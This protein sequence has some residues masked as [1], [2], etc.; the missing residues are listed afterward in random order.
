MP[1]RPGS[2]AR[3]AVVAAAVI[4]ALAADGVAHAADCGSTDPTSN[5]P[6]RGS[7]TLV[8]TSSNPNLRFHR[9]TNDHQ[10]TLT[11]TVSGCDVPA[12]PPTVNEKVLALSDNQLPPQAVE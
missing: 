7:L 3:A 8:L 10:I 6:V 5:K 2:R 4:G 12:Q 1:H 9:H 11:Y